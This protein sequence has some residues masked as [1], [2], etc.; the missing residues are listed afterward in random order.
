MTIKDICD[1][2]RQCDSMRATAHQLN[3]SHGV[4]RKCLIG[5]G[6][7]DSPLIRR[8]ADLRSSG[9]DSVE[10]AKALD[11]SVAWVNANSPY[12][13]GLMIEPSQTENAKKIR[14]CRAK[15]NHQEAL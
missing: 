9:M 1:V 8:I 5:A 4:V 3:I 15:K 10:I 11:I 12:E 7:L 13:R 2:Y 14:A 6:L